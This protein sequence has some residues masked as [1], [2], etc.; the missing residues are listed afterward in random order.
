MT[1]RS[2]FVS[3]WQKITKDPTGWGALLLFA[4]GLMVLLTLMSIMP[5]ASS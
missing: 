5:Y 4:I 2:I 3:W 1:I